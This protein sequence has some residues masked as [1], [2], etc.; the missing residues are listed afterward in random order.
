MGI[1]VNFFWAGDNF[2]YIN[3]MC[4]Q[5]HVKVGHQIIIWLYGEIPDSQHWYNLDFSNIIVIDASD[6]FDISSFMK[7]SDANFRT[8]SALWRFTFLYK[9]GGWYSDC[10]AYAIKEWPNSEWVLCSGEE[11]EDLLSIGVLKTPPKEE[12]FLDMID[13]IQHKWGNVKVFNT[14]LRKHK[15]HTIKP[16]NPTDFYPFSWKD[17]D[18]MLSNINIPDTYS[19]HLYNTMVQRNM[20]DIKGFIDE[21]PNSL[22]GKLDAFIHG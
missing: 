11:D 9:Y 4:I 13:N 18:Y 3:Y 21:R 8:A 17:W 5:S 16:Y 12:M 7:H 20:N 14:Y 15:D 1:C 6:I 2:D 10:D 19:V 22:L